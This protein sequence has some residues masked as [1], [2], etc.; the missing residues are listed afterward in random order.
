MDAFS[1]YPRVCKCFATPESLFERNGCIIPL[2]SEQV[3]SLM[4]QL[5]AGKC[6][7][8]HIPLHTWEKT[9]YTPELR[10]LIHNSPP[11]GLRY[12]GRRQWTTVYFGNNHG[13]YTR[14]LAPVYIHVRHHSQM[15]LRYQNIATL[16]CNEL[17]NIKPAKKWWKH[18]AYLH[19]GFVQLRMSIR[20]I[21]LQIAQSHTYARSALCKDVRWLIYRFVF[22]L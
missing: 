18:F 8:I 13:L 17:Y 20:S 6:F 4:P 2:T 15:H 16:A 7:A 11:Y 3:D 9:H 19:G 10:S 14:Y 5:R 1:H 21:I 12:V 22:T